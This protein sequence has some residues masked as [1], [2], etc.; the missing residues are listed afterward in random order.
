MRIIHTADWH[1]GQSFHGQERH[2]EHKA[3]LDWLI[4]V[5]EDHA[6]DA[7][8]VAG[9]V[10][11]VVNP[12]L[13]AQEML[14]DFIV[15][16]HQRCP[17]LTLVLIAGN[18]DSGSRIE[19]PAPLMRHLRTYALGRVEF[20]DDGHIDSERLLVP[21]TDARGEVGAWCLALPFLRPAEITGRR[22]TSDHHSDRHD[23]YVSSVERVHRELIEAARRKRTDGQALIAMS[24][25]HLRGAAVSEASERPIVIGGEESLSASLFPNDIDY[26]ALGHLH[27][28]QRVGEERIR[29]SGSP[30]PL[31]FSEVDYPHQVL[32]LSLDNG[33]LAK[34]EPLAVPRAVTMRRLG[35][36]S[37]D[38][39]LQAID[40]LPE[41]QGSGPT[42]R[43]DWLEINVRL[44]APMPELRSRVEQALA[45][46]AV[47]LLRLKRELPSSAEQAPQRGERLEDI[48]PRELFTRTWREAWGEEPEQDVLADFD[49]LCQQVQ[50]DDA[51]ESASRQGAST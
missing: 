20:I 9:D 33:T 44:E 26:V 25:A 49:G 32:L 4:Q 11:D 39:L 36:A 13:R 35:P 19:L 40:D 1:L 5:A 8:L 7:L 48:G 17:A 43:W 18:H 24:H 15:E 14:Y 38:E 29:Y 6:A 51:S 34:V 16:L 22:R 28:A 45:T 10:F 42:E 12:S 27:R 3:F 50:D 46:K 31:D 37:L 23:D 30:L 2:E 21:L 47:R 41:R